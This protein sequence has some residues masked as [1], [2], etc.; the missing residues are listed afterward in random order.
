MKRGQMEMIGLVFIVLLIT[1][2]MLFFVR[3]SL[4]ESESKKVYTRSGLATSTMS[5]IMK[6]TIDGNYYYCRPPF[7]V[8]SPHLTLGTDL[9]Q[10]CA[11]WFPNSISDY[12]CGNKHSC[13]FLNE[14]ITTLLNDTL[15]QWGKNY[16][17]TST[18]TTMD[19]NTKELLKIKSNKGCPRHVDRD[20]S[21]PFPINVQRTGFVENV[22][23]ICD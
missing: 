18:L 20:T 9:L 6:T 10:D 15:G 17:Y 11:K 23:Y 7:L 21:V 2:G 3:F 16:E 12:K 22:I 1:I 4:D 5:A 14:T 19:G 13:V 8:S